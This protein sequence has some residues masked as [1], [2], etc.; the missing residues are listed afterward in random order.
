M[1][2]RASLERKISERYFGGLPVIDATESLRIFVNREDIETASPKDPEACVYAQAC[3]RL[4]GSNTVVFLRTKAY[5]DLPDEKGNRAVHRFDLGAKVRAQIRLFDQ[6]GEASPG[7]FLLSAPSPTQTL[8]YQ[9]EYTKI[10][11]ARKALGI[12]PKRRAAISGYTT[13]HG[14][15]DEV[16]NGRGMVHFRKII[17]LDAPMQSTSQV[18]VIVRTKKERKHV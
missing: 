18:P 9:R 6:T 15:L 12:T 3:R 7:G 8:D 5:I 10:K 16:R 1:S 17:D 14:K 13:I 2:K 4:Y 11:R